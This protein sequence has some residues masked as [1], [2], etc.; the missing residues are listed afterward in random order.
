MNEIVSYSKNELSAIG[1]S[2]S[3]ETIP[4]SRLTNTQNKDKNK[5]SIDDIITIN[6]K[7]NLTKP[8]H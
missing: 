5:A 7:V 2:V 4:S 8:Q 3:P 6:E 1:P